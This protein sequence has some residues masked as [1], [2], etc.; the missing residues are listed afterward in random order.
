MDSISVYRENLRKQINA[1]SQEKGCTIH[2]VGILTWCNNYGASNFGQVLQCYAMQK[3]MNEFGFEARIILYH[4]KSIRVT[5]T[6]MLRIENFQRFINK[7]INVSKPCYSKSMVEEET[8]DCEMLVCGS[9]QIWSPLNFDPVWFLDFGNEKQLR[10]AIAPSGIFFENDDNR[11]ILRQMSNLIR[12]LDYVSVREKSG[13]DILSKYVG[14]EVDVL[15]DPTLLLPEKYWHDLIRDKGKN[16][17]YALCCF[18]G[19]IGAF[20]ERVQAIA[21]EYDASEIRD[22]PSNLVK[23]PFIPNANNFNGC[24]PSEFLEQIFNAKVVVTDSYHCVIFGHIFD[25]PVFCA[26]R[27]QSK[28]EVYGSKQRFESLEEIIGKRIKFL[29]S[30]ESAS[31]VDF[32]ESYGKSI[33]ELKHWRMPVERIPNGS[34]VAIYGFGD[35]GK[36]YY[37]QL[38]REKD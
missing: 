10:I 26:Y 9:D 33:V 37:N 31:K 28:S 16:G 22:I 35:V 24:G 36:D 6:N 20:Y 29:T 27:Q 15:P 13:S 25:V 19:Q 2:R 30:D 14:R 1:I 38:I 3:L 12:K 8:D 5:D 7:Y 23:N 11:E 17:D 21:D 18:L 32:G 34:R 4:N